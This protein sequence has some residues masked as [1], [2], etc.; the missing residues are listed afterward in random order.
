MG[1][2]RYRRTLS[3]STLRTMMASNLHQ[4]V[5]GG[6]G[7]GGSSKGLGS[8]NLKTNAQLRSSRPVSISGH[9]RAPLHS[10]QQQ[11]SG[12]QSNNCSMKDLGDVNDRA[13]A[14]RKEEDIWAERMHTVWPKFIVGLWVG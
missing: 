3:A 14:E 12:S 5:K 4:I 13:A 6:G 7:D 10:V 2:N 1:S 11:Q 9:H 8:P